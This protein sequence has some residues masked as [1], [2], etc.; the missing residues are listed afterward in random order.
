MRGM[1]FVFRPRLSE[2]SDNRLQE[3]SDIINH[4]PEHFG[5]FLYNSKLDIKHYNII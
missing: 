3:I 1:A 2:G 5:L 4:L